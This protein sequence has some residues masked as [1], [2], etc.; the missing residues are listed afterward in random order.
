MPDVKETRPPK[1]YRE[2]LGR[3]ADA[4]IDPRRCPVCGH[5][6]LT[7]VRSTLTW[8]I[9]ALL[10]AACLYIVLD[11]AEDGRLDGS[12]WHALIHGGA[13]STRH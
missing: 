5:R 12:I 11:V 2:W 3:Q 13:V 8:V 7:P 1:T 4:P 6:S 9:A 10:G